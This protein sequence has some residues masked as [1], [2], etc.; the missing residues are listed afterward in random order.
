MVIY[1]YSTHTHAHTHI[2][3]Y[4]YIYNIYIYIYIYIYGRWG[5]WNSPQGGQVQIVEIYVHYVN[6]CIVNKEALRVVLPFSILWLSTLCKWTL[7]YA[8]IFSYALKVSFYII[9]IPILHAVFVKGKYISGSRTETYC[10][11]ICDL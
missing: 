2:Y 6:W 8:S 3:I 9:Y 11:C 7:D 4:I 10:I 5:L 1:V